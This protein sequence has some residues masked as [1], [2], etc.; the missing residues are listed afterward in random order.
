MKMVPK[1]KK[2]S[3]GGQDVGL[4]TQHKNMAMGKQG[5]VSPTKNPGSKS[6]GARA[7]IKTRN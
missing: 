1:S 3:F 2:P 5:S 6:G 7:K 4:I